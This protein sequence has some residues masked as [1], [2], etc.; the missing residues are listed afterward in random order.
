MKEKKGPFFLYQLNF[1][2][3]SRL[4]RQLNGNVLLRVDKE[5]CAFLFVLENS[6]KK[7]F[8]LVCTLFVTIFEVHVVS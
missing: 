3:S 1:D 2:K 7:L 6:S 4:L 5:M 8:I